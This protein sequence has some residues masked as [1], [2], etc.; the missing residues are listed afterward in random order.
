ME[1]SEIDPAT[2][3]FN[4]ARQRPRPR[5]FEASEAMDACLVA[6]EDDWF[7]VMEDKAAARGY[8]IMI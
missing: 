4:K 1:E 7:D 2:E 6:K 8:Q 3:G 5:S